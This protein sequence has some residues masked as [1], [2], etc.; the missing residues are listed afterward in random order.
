M[1]EMK[2]FRKGQLDRVSYR[3]LLK[4]E[5][6][7]RGSGPDAALLKEPVPTESGVVEDL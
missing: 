2:G 5:E 6:W 3:S 4:G 1:A 7:T